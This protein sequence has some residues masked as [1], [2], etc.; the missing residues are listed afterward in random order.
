[1]ERS[2]SCYDESR[3][4]VVKIVDSCPC[5]HANAYSNARWCCG[6]MK[7]VTALSCMHDVFPTQTCV[8]AAMRMQHP[9]ACTTAFASQSSTPP[10]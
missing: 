6:D 7:W 1:M 4:V 8:H 2:S 5:V 3:T 10:N 9:H